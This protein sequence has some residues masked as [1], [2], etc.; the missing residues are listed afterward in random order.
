[1]IIEQVVTCETLEEAQINLVGQK[2]L[3]RCILTYIRMP[4]TNNQKPEVVTLHRTIHPYE[5][6]AGWLKKGQRQ[7]S[8]LNLVSR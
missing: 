1:M 7:V 5:D 3:P 6:I 4:R 8:S 2:Q